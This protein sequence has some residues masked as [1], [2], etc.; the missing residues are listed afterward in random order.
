ML[1][2]S[3]IS[4]SDLRFVLTSLIREEVSIKDITNIFE[5]INDFAEDC[6]KS[7]LINK[8]RLTLSRQICR[9]YANE[10]GV[11]QAFEIS[12]KALFKLTPSLDGDDDSI[13]RIDGGF[14]EKLAGKI[15]KQAKQL[16]IDTP[17][18]LAP[19]ELRQLLFSMLSNYIDNIVVL[20]HEEIGCNAKI[21]I[22]AEV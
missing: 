11:I 1:F 18:L 15:A 9:K 22:I 3:F 6:S 14:A 8:I 4:L 16:E 5:K 2:R 20:A 12:E 17:K 13:I 19:L 21:E 7:D 10:D